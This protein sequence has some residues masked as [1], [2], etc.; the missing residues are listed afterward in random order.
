M[1]VSEVIRGVISAGFLVQAIESVLAQIYQ[2]F[3]IIVVDDASEDNT[4]SAVQ[5]FGNRVCYIRQER[6]G[7]SVARNRGILQSRGELIAFLDADDLWRPTKL[8]RQVE[9]MAH[10]P[11]AVLVY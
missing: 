8:A 4:E 11:E 3:E 9:Y 1:V 2:D 7:P 10:H 5:R 6:C